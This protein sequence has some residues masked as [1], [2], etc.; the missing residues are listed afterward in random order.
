MTNY[1]LQAQYLSGQLINTVKAVQEWLKN[2][3]TTLKPYNSD[4]GLMFGELE[5][6]IIFE[7]II[8]VFSFCT[9]SI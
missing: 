3:P 2:K 4:A 9:T 7:S 6:T 5:P 1:F 8:L